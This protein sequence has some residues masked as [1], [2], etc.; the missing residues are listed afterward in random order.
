[1]RKLM[2]QSA[3]MLVLTFLA[4]VCAQCP[5]RAEA[6]APTPDLPSARGPQRVALPYAFT[7][8]GVE[9]RFDS[10]EFA[11][12]QLRVNITLHETRG[13]DAEL[14]ASKLIQARTPAGQVLSFAGYSRAGKLQRDP[15]IHVAPNGE[16]SV[17]LNYKFASA[18]AAPGS[19][20]ELR[21][22]TGKWWSSEVPE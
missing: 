3:A 8:H 14:L 18:G 1:M 17:V 7:R 19:P 12:G 16:F 6:D 20:V 2:R 11:E 22:P 15:T 4:A 13:Q 10:I 5:S 21:F 9:I